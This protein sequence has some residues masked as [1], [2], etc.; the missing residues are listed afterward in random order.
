MKRVRVASVIANLGFGGSENRLLSFATAVDRT[1]FDHLV[2]TLYRRE[3]ANE[4]AIGSRRQAYADAGITLIDLDER[5]RRRILPSRRPADLL[6]A[7]GALRRMLGR[8]C[9]LVRAREIELIDAQHST[10]ALMGGLAGA[11]TGRAVTITEY[12]PD[13]FD[14]PG[15]RLLGH[16]LY[17]RADA[18][19]CD[20]KAHSDLVNRWLRRPHRRSLVIPNGIPVPAVTR[21]NAEMRERL[22]IPADRAVRVVGQVSRLVPHKGQRALLRAARTVLSVVPDTV[23]VITG[24][25]GED[26]PYLERLKRDARE[27]GIEDRV[28][29]VSWPGSIGDIWELLDIHVHASV[30]ESL[31]IA[32][33]EGMAFGK[34]AVVT[35]VGG[36]RE[37][38]T[39]EET[40]LVVPMHDPEALAA[41]ILRLLREPETARRLGAAALRRYQSGYRPEVM[42][43][44]LESLFLEIVERRRAGA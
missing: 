33:T 17:H 13:Y 29:F 6:R 34:P 28:R 22:G 7:G 18:F 4:R 30:Q 3:E 10:G 31:P 39:H 16:A 44:A 1:R 11:L 15:M 38:V 9:R 5:A 2:V 19:I 32:I 41:G 12:Y 42:T 43:R 27:L 35:D 36:V 24:Y 20:S 26:P 14:R 8:L 21:S 25:A 37:M 40:G 23:F